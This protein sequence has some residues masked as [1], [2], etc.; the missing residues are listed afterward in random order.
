MII[1]TTV[2]Y[3]SQKLVEREKLLNF[4]GFL[5]KNFTILTFDAK[6][7]DVSIKI[8]LK[9]SSYDFE[10]TLQAVCAKTNNYNTIITNDKKFPNID[11]IVLKRT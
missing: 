5:N 4:I 9:N 11:G 1:V 3:L 8:C 10:D 2:F 7:I 6:I